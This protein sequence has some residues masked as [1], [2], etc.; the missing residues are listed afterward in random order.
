MTIPEAWVEAC[1]VKPS[2]DLLILK[3]L[4]SSSVPSSMALSCGSASI[5]SSKVIL[6]PS[7]MSLAILS[8]SA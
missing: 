1:L 8:A 7:G 2:K 5:A 6:M 3:S 4:L